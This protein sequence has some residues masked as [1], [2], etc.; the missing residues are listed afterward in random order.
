MPEFETISFKAR[1]YVHMHMLHDLPRM[2]AVI[3]IDV[4]SVSGNGFFNDG[5]QRTHDVYNGR[6]IFRRNVKNI[7]GVSLGND[8]RVA[9]V[10]G[11]DVQKC[12]R[13]VV[14]INFK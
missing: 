9:G 4:D 10:H 12:E 13:I 5:S 6:P 3:H 14:L 7:F 2:L 1:D 11:A 8:K